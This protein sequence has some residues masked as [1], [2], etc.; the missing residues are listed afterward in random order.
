MRLN[1]RIACTLVGVLI[2]LTLLATA[3][4]SVFATNFYSTNSSTSVGTPVGNAI[5]L[6]GK[7]YP[8][9]APAAVVANADDWSH[10]AGA[11][12]LA[13]AYGGPL[14]LCSSSGLSANVTTELKRLNPGT[15]YVVGLA[16]TVV[17]QI[18]AAL[19]GLSPRPQVVGL[20]G[21]DAYE[22]AV[23]VARQVQVKLGTVSRVVLIPSDDSSG[24]LAG[25]AMAAANGWPILLTPKGGPF[26]QVSTNAIGELGA[27]VGICVGTTASP[28]I[29][30]FSVE[31]ALTGTISSSDP[32]GRQSLCATTAEYAVAQGYSSFARVGVVE[33]NDRVGGQAVSAYVAGGDGVVLL[34]LGSGLSGATTE[35]MQAHGTEISEVDVVG[36][37]WAIVRQIKSLNS[38]RVT[39]VSPNSGPVSGETTVVV[40]GSG[41]DTASSVIVGKV[42]VPT[43]DWRA[44]SGTQLTILSN[45]PADGAGPAEV[46]VQNYWGRSPATTNGL[47]SY[48]DGSP[49]LPGDRVV[50]EALK[51]LGVPYVWAGSIPSG[52]LDCS[53]FTTYVYSRLGVVLPRHSSDQAAYGTPISREML[54]PG[55]IVCFSD[56]TGHV[57]HV[58]IYV[59]GGLMINSPRSGDLVTIENAFRSSYA[60]ARRILSP[61]TRYQDNNALLT[62]VGTWGKSVTSLASGGSF[63]WLN[64][65]GFMSVKFNGTYLGWIGKK[66]PQYGKAWVRVDGGPAITV[67]TYSARTQYRTAIWATGLLSPGEHTVTIQWTGSKNSRASGY[68]VGVDA[69]DLLG[70]LVKAPSLTRYQ[71]NDAHLIYAGYW[72]PAYSSLASLGS[73]R[74]AG[75]P[76]S[77]TVNFDGT[78]LAW[79]TKK[80]PQY[81]KARV[82]LDG[83][84]PV[85]VDLYRAS[86][87][88][89]QS[90]YRTGILP[91]GP[92][93][94][95]IQWTGSK[96]ARARG[97]LIGVDAIDVV[98]ELTD[99]P[100]APSGP[101]SVRYEQTDPRVGYV[102]Y[103]GRTSNVLASAGDCAY[104]N[105]TAKLVVGFKGTSLSWIAK[106]SSVY[107]IANVTLDD[108]AP[109]QVDLYSPTALFQQRVYSTGELTDGAHTLT[110]EWTGSKN[111]ASTD[112]NVGA[113]AFDITGE[114]IQ[115]P[116]LSRYEE[117]AVEIAY[118]GTWQPLSPA[119]SASGGGAVLANSP[120]ASATISFDGTYIS[121]IAKKSSL[122]GR[123]KVFLDGGAPVTVDLYSSSAAW[124]E[125][126]WNSGVLPAGQHT[127]TIQWGWGR[128]EAATDTNLSLD[129]VEVMGTLTQATAAV[130][131][132]EPKLVVIDP[133]HQLHANSALEPVG[134]G[135]ATMKAKVS[136]GT[137]SVNTGSPESALVLNVGLKLRESLRAYGLDVVMTR[138][139]QSVDVSN[140]QRAQMANEA[141]ADLFV[142]IHADG[143]TDQS[144]NGILMLYPATITGWT[145][146]IAAESKRGA[147]LALQELIKATGARDRGLSARSDLA[148]FNW[149]DVPTFLAE[150]GLMTNPAEDQ[151]LA[152]DA[153]QD[154]IVS[155]LTL[156]ILSFLDAY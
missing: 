115:A 30:G 76:A 136:A 84:A 42:A 127:L 153:Y 56:G 139:T 133:G 102:G 80:S 38:P 24:A 52:G 58:G 145:D 50:N 8:S 118:A 91:D 33:Y 134:P 49:G 41:L 94:V 9:G 28:T 39:L 124:Q 12:V 77:V 96:N 105:A 79:I 53:G 101:A 60:G 140:A 111:P 81:G 144:V 34:S 69:F 62:T 141:G 122:Y 63:R 37:S 21:A 155:G 64:S 135:S 92:H 57:G 51:Y 132:S 4:G 26:P 17:G 156:A 15:V 138:E 1:R 83:G 6:S 2:I 22:T 130:M 117:N 106:K 89:K 100:V 107:G 11:S 65:S 114:L 109:V 73:F 32:D 72:A 90:V 48:A 66:G 67:D 74:Y 149:S 131:H 68:N 43:S 103:W 152:T 25:S 150:I 18:D 70:S 47:Y 19:A 86:G 88:Q 10:A 13:R 151:L 95:T 82:T 59:G 147:A 143:A 20:I 35:I 121:W 112:Y 29:D 45:S 120:G 71:Q 31:K 108:G 97:N 16:A 78:Y 93:T 98:G 128:N 75:S 110:I 27:T 99:A 125:R 36:L 7:A 46:I 123:A 55:D 61:Y 137:A 85:T 142:R 44:D 3:S 116:G 129:A 87:L 5:I 154:K 14:L 126:V 104:A 54:L 23:L 119:A 146:D 40:T 113:D 148:G